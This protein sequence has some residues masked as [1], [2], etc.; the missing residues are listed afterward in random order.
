[1]AETLN[2]I[3]CKEGQALIN[4]K[5]ICEQRRLFKQL[6]KDIRVQVIC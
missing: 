4:T 5:I 2:R 3:N 1:M 6:Q